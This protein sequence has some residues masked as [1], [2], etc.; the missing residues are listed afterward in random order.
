MDKERAYLAALPKTTR[1]VL[2]KNALLL[3]NEDGSTVLQFLESGKV[4]TTPIIR[5]TEFR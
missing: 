5:Q 1:A 2:Q 3:Q 4:S